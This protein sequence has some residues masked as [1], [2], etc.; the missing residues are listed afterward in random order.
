MSICRFIEI[1]QT[2]GGRNLLPNPIGMPRRTNYN[3]IAP[4]DQWH[5]YAKRGRHALASPAMLS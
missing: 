4:L 5:L 2:S 3:S 1:L